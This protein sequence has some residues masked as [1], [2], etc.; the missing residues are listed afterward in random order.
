MNLR[1]RPQFRLTALLS[2]VGMVGLSMASTAFAQGIPVGSGKISDTPKAGYVYSCQQN[3]NKNAPGARATGDW[4]KGDLWYPELKPTVG[5]NVSWD[6]GGVEQDVRNGT[7]V[8]TTTNLPTHGTG[9]Y[10]VRRTDD[11]YEFDRNPNRI[12]AQNIT[13]RLPANPQAARSPSC[14]PM[15]M[16]GISLTGAAIYNALDARGDD[17]PANEIQDSCGGHPERQGQYHYHGPTDCMVETGASPDGHSGLIGYALDGFGLYGLR[18]SGGQQISNTNLDACHG[19]TGPVLQD[20]EMRALYH[21]HLTREYPY[22][23]GCFT[24]AP[25]AAR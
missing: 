20:G 24:G 8:L 4:I 17:A 21:Y 25:L 10:P 15:G 6:N 9:I 3:F 12:S 2:L 7:R 14:L 5:G 22:T 16:I 18:G 1:T 11:A 13:L 19:H 23:L